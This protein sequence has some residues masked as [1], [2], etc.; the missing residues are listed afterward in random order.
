MIVEV[1]KTNVEEVELSERIIQ[2]LSAQFPES[3][4]NFDI[5]DCDKILRVEAAEV[6][7]EKIIQILNSNGY[8]CEILL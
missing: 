6:S 2:Q 1:F 3:L 8:S 5:D 4:I 7:P